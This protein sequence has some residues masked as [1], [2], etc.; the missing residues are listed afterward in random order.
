M[1][2]HGDEPVYSEAARS[3]C[4]GMKDKLITMTAIARNGLHRARKVEVSRRRFGRRSARS[5]RLFG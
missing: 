1:Q 5:G 2:R 3:R 4:R